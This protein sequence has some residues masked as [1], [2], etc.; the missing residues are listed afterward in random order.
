L[1]LLNK[2]TI[3]T[4]YYQK[5]NEIEKEILLILG[6]NSIIGEDGYLYDQNNSYSVK[7]MSSDAVVYSID[8]ERF[9]KRMLPYQ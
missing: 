3:T 7:C 8:S 6:P 9:T 1:L 5:V 4:G 2:I